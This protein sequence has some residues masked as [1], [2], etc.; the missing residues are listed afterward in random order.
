MLHACLSSL[1][2]WYT[3]TCPRSS[4]NG[5]M[6]NKPSVMLLLPLQLLLLLL[7]LLKTLLTRPACAAAAL[8]TA[9]CRWW[10]C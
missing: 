2:T 10:P 1:C 4:T 8:P 9:C 6:S 7:P 3:H 5:K